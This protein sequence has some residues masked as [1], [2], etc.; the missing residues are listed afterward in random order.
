[1]CLSVG[2]G[3]M[4][5]RLDDAPAQLRNWRSRIVA[6]SAFMLSP[7]MRLR[8][9]LVVMV[10]V[11]VMVMVIALVL[12]RSRMGNAALFSA[13]LVVGLIA[14]VFARKTAPKT[15]ALI[16][17]L[18]I[19]DVLVVGTWVG[20]ERVVERIQDTEMTI[21]AGGKSESVEA[22]T[23]AARTALP[24]VWDFPWWAPGVAAFTTCS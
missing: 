13:M 4:L 18:V 23:E 19:S 17:S 20:L 7:K 14:I 10:M 24:I 1:M 6:A 8:L 9:L 2:I 5:A 21:A 15:I 3:L 16:T 22:R 12:T 11:M